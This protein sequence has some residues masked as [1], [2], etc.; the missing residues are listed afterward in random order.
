MRLLWLRN[1]EQ[2]V[3]ISRGGCL[4]CKPIEE[5]YRLQ[6]LR[7]ALSPRGQERQDGLLGFAVD[8][9]YF[10]ALGRAM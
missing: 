5:I 2:G 1:C 4:T 9:I 3:A 8:S 10:K 6:I 7:F